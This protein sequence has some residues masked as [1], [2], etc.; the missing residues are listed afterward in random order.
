M[1]IIHEKFGMKWF[2]LC[3]ALILISGYLPWHVAAQENNGTT[4]LAILVKTEEGQPIKDAV[5]EIQNE[6]K[7]VLET[8][9]S[10][11]NGRA[12]IKEV[13]DGDYQLVQ[14]KT[15]EEYEPAVERP[16]EIKAEVP[17]REEII[18]NKPSLKE[19]EDDPSAVNK[20]V[21]SE[22]Y[23]E[24]THAVEKQLPETTGDSVKEDSSEVRTENNTI[25]ISAGDVA[26]N[27]AQNPDSTT[28]FT[29]S[30]LGCAGKN[31][32]GSVLFPTWTE[33]NGQN[34]LVWYQ[35]TLG[36]NGEYSVTIDSKDHG[37]ETGIYNVH[38]YIY[39]LQGDVIKTCV[40]T[41]KMADPT[42]N[43]SVGEVSND[44]YNV[45]VT[46]VSSSEGVSGVMFPT[47][48]QSNGQDD[49]RWESGIYVGNDTWEA[50]INLKN[51]RSSYDTFIT[52]AY[53]VKE[54]Q[55]LK[56]IS[57]TEKTINNPFQAEP[58][59][60]EIQPDRDVSKFVISTKNCSGKSGIG[61]VLFPVWT[62]RNG[63]DD[64]QWIQGIL[65]SNGEY[66]AVVDIENHGFETGPYLIHAYLYGNGDENIAF[67]NNSF[68]LE[69]TTPTFEYDNAVLNNVFKMRIKNVSNENGVSGVMLPTWSNIDGQD[70]IRWEQTTY[71]G[72]HTWE[73]TVDLKKY[74]QIVDT[75][76]TH[77]YLID[78]NGNFVMAAQSSR[79]IK[80]NTATVYGYFAYPLDTQYQ[81]NPDDPTDWFGARW[82]DIHE[83]IDI[84]ADRYANCYS[85][86]NGTVEKAGYFMGYGRYVRI[87]T[88]DRYGES[89]SFFYGHLQEINV[90]VGQNVG[91]GTKIGAVGGSGF[92]ANGNYIDNAY[93]SHLHFGAIANADDACVDPEIWIDFHNPYNNIN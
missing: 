55:Q 46:G 89:V 83:G 87:R 38:T 74:N 71:I 78:K 30:T 62:T 51:Y 70:D 5:F 12:E 92:D 76:I 7:E 73:T 2:A 72:N 61:Y 1:Q 57:Q 52:H 50:T 19:P 85:V 28:Q 32:I 91:I 64:I 27:I 69:K 33:R 11:E 48:S 23:E 29:V 41:Y 53:V 67:S 68:T 16:I 56:Y 35:G 9:I 44:S 81:P 22:Q 15:Q 43:I 4:K 54:N 39:G 6:Q 49:I 26:V 93:G 8:C 14:I 25:S 36:S 3:L 21:G 13:D 65:G 58:L 18:I 63:Q 42:A 86:C 34:D 66:S 79:T 17:I 20:K 45:R 80:Q 60:L 88:T 90:S 59:E 10:D 77:A 31:G 75:F 24:D 37:F 82:G 84:P 47:W 40:N